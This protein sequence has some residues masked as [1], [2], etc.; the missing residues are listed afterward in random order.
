MKQ[1]YIKKRKCIEKEDVCFEKAQRE[2]IKNTGF[3]PI[4]LELTLL[5]A[6]TYN[7]ICI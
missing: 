6:P 4:R 5:S 7:L 3:S 1:M 2:G